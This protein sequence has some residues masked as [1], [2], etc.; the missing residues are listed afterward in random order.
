MVLNL[1]TN[2]LTSKT[3]AVLGKIIAADHT[4]VEYKFADCMLSEDGKWFQF[5]NSHTVIVKYIWQ[6]LVKTDTVSE[7]F[8]EFYI[9]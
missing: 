2:S 3:C 9:K 4:F 5:N 8:S 6:S 7:K 1:S